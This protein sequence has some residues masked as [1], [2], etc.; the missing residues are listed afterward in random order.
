MKRPEP[1]RKRPK[2][3]PLLVPIGAGIGVLALV[4]VGLSLLAGGDNSAGPTP[5]PS[6]PVTDTTPPGTG[7]T[8][9]VTGTTPS[10]S[11]LTP[12]ITA[13]I[14][15]ITPSTG[16][17]PTY[18][19]PAGAIPVAFGVSVVPV[20]GWSPLASETQG[21]Q[22]V[23]YAPNAEPRAFLW[24][25]QKLNATAKNYVLAIVEGETTNEIAQL[26]NSRNLPCP[27]DVLVECVAI[28][29]T[30]TSK[31]VKVQGFV[32]AYRR[33]DGVTTA[34]DFRTRVDFA[35]T[36]LADSNLMRKSVIDS[37]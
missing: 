24:V 21:K 25:R 23:N 19:P 34:L 3:P 9:S 16:P 15:P 31:G 2:V 5:G 11:G 37:L 1:G 28:T 18:T 29:Y 32:E 36:A 22:L 27:R 7:A 35:P 14:T 13:P 12:S 10:I 4:A 8:S 30:S 26:G 33:K 6:T 17:N 20:A